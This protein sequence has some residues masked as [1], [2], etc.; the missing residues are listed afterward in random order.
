[1][2]KLINFLGESTDTDAQ[3]RMTIQI[4][5]VI[6]ERGVGF[7]YKICDNLN[8]PLHESRLPQFNHACSHTDDF[9]VL[10]DLA[11]A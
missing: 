6:K 7:F 8:H 1:M 5:E 11:P 9:S 4:N 10:C 3:Q 2:E